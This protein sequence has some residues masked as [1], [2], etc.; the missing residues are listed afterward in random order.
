MLFEQV[1][2]DL[3]PFGFPGRFKRSSSLEFEK[4]FN[5]LD[6]ILDVFDILTETII[7]RGQVDSVTPTENQA[8]SESVNE[9]GLRWWRDG[10]EWIDL[11]LILM[12]RGERFRT[13]CF[14]PLGLNE[15]TQK[16][17]KGQV[18]SVRDGCQVW[19]FDLHK[20]YL[21]FRLYKANRSWTSWF[22]KIPTFLS[23]DIG[24]PRV[25]S[26]YSNKSEYKIKETEN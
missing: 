24:W 5:V 2:N 18:M 14:Q 7:D 3:D 15:F 4:L 26:V 16:K 21:T 9:C 13:S 1:L 25:R 17:K 22:I 11:W 20:D 19:W 23:A 8:R 6:R 12:T 10:G